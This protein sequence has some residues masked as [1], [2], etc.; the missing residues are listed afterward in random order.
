MAEIAVSSAELR[1]N[2]AKTDAL[3]AETDAR[4][5]RAEKI[6]SGIGINLGS[7]AEEYFYYSLEQKMELG[8]MKFD[9]IERN[10]KIK[11]KKREAEFDLV[12]FNGNS[13]AIIEVK[14]KV[15]PRDV[16]ILIDKKVDDFRNLMP[17]YAAY[18]VYLGVAGKSVPIEVERM[19]IEKGVAV[20]RQ[21]GEVM[22]IEDKN[23][24]VY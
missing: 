21:I 1:K 4:L 12:L 23:L 18:N 10:I 20:L 15:H 11:T 7:T 5:K 13:V 9:E 19:A 24:K 22:E 3:M 2:Q 6:F 16:Q 14:H 17:D 8:G